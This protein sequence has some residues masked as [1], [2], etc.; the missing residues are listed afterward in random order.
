M[1]FT[2]DN[3][4]KS[5]LGITHHGEQV[6]NDEEFTPTIE[7]FINSSTL[8]FHHLLSNVMEPNLG[9]EHYLRLKLKSRKR[10][11]LYWMNLET[12]NRQG[13]CVLSF[14]QCEN[15]RTSKIK[16]CAPC[17]KLLAALIIIF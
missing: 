17:A 14:H 6:D 11:R 4:L 13:S 10:Y 5:E 7:N 1:A 12:L 8:S 2:E 3:L 16:K 15:H 9:P